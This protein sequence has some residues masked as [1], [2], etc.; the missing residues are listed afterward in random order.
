MKKKKELSEKKPYS[1]LAIASVC[2]LAVTVVFTGVPY[3]IAKIIQATRLR[4]VLLMAAWFARFPLSL[5][6]FT[7][8]LIGVIRIRSRHQNGLWLA[9]LGLV[10]GAVAFLVWSFVLFN[11]WN[12]CGR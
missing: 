10:L 7:L 2:M 11:R 3:L 6:A 1:L 4:N 5:S 9:I 8:G 12:C